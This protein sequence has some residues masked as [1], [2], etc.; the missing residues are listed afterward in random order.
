MSRTDHCA[1]AD[2]RSGFRDDTDQRLGSASNWGTAA[3]HGVSREELPEFHGNV[4]CQAALCW[5]I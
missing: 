1:F 3:V 5:R 4:P 2:H